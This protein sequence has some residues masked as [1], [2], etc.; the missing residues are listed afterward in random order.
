M[1]A[2]NMEKKK[3]GLAPDL[4]LVYS[5][6]DLRPENLDHIIRKT[7]FSA[8]KVC[9]ILTELEL[10]GLVQ[11]KSIAGARELTA[12]ENRHVRIDYRIVGADMLVA[13]TQYESK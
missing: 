11:R 13:S 1:P 4:D 2:T 6:L 8:A 5:G 10:M 7:G 12:G 3:L 9:A